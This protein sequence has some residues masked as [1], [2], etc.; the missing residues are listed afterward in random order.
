MPCNFSRSQIELIIYLYNTG[1]TQVEI[2]KQLNCSQVT[3]SNI[4]KKIDQE[5]CK[6]YSHIKI[7]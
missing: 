4:L 5:I 7:I 2:A 1:K 3:I 6:E